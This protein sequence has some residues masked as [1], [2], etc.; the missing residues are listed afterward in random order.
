[1]NEEKCRG[2]DPVPT[3]KEPF[4]RE[5]VWKTGGLLAYAVSAAW[6]YLL[7]PEWLPIGVTVLF[8][9]LVCLWDW[10]WYRV[11]NLFTYPTMAIG[12]IYH[13]LTT[14][15]GGMVQS[16]EGLLLGGALLLV[17]YLFKA[18]GAGDV[19]ALAALGAWWGPEPV[20]EIFLATGLLGGVVSFVILAAKGKMAATAKRYWLMVKVLLWTRKFHYLEPSSFEGKTPLPYGVIISFGVVLWFILGKFRW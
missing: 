9:T 3:R 7:Q 16:L 12:V 4:L 17:A 19:K 14:G 11:P 18:V 1:M 13:A 20:F 6:L 2:R 8:L 10:R 5:I 15:W